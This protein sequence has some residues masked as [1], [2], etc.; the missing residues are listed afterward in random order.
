[1]WATVARLHGYEGS[2]TTVVAMTEPSY[3]SFTRAAYDT[4]AVDYAELLSAELAT[5]PWDRALLSLFAERV[6]ATG[7]GRVGDLGCGPGR[8]T[9]Y[10]HS[11]GVNAFGLDLSPGMV[12]EARS[13]HPDLSFDVGS[14]TALDMA[15][16]ALAGIV[17]WY[18][19]IHTPPELLPVVFAEFHRVL[20]PAG[21]LLLAFQTGDERV[22]R[23]EAYGHA[24]S[25]DTYRSPPDRIADLLGG[26]GFEVSARVLRDPEKLEKL[27]QA[28][29][30][31]R[32][33]ATAARG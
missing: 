24:V 3:L 1:M 9:A 2:S 30:L 19:I 6:L 17:A 29:L 32:R 11:L 25:L 7:S 4:V 33:A 31:A 18:S 26:A 13:R 22:R 21:H 27:P 20:G 10:L 14:I 23:D 12:A 28:Y 8:V 15:N 16:G 5:N